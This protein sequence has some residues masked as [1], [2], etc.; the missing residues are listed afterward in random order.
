MQNSMKI[1]AFL[2]LISVLSGCNDSKV[3]EKITVSEVNLSAVTNGTYHGHYKLDLPFGYVIG[4]SAASVEVIVTG[5]RFQSIHLTDLPEWL[6]TNEGTKI[7][8]MLNQILDKQRLNV[9][10][11]TGASFTKKAIQK[12]IE[13]AFTNNLT[14][15]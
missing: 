13:N 4:Q 7:Q 14:N 11:A 5:N 12:S 8:E 1:T 6:T 10:S 3:L 9:D 2:I 15:Y